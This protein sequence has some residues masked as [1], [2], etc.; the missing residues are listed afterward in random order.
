MPKMPPLNP[1]HVF[2]VAARSGSFSRA[3]QEMGVTQSAVSRQVFTLEEYLGTKLFVR[4]SRGIELTQDGRDYI[5]QISPA[6]EQIATATSHLL[7]RNR[8]TAVRVAAYPTFAGKWLI[9]RLKA[10]GQ[11]NRGTQIKIKTSIS[12]VDPETSAFD[13]AIQLRPMSGVDPEFSLLLYRDVLQPFCSPAFLKQHRLKSPHDLLSVPLLTSHYRKLDWRD[14]LEGA[15]LPPQA[16]EGDEF[17]SSLLTYRAAQEGLGV[18]IGQP[19]LVSDEI[20][21][22][23][24]VPVFQPIERDLGLFV[25]WTRYANARVR[26]FVKW[27][28]A[29]VERAD[30]GHPVTLPGQPPISRR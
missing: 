14:W 5:E 24:L 25:I 16:V 11:V 21:S 10:F 30:D 9:P 12:P 23:Q 17:P 8:S 20:G 4:E 27:L 6:M 26:S 19:F 22:G 28:A 15:G 1:L 3:A 7:T 18:A 29:E 13:V 2:H